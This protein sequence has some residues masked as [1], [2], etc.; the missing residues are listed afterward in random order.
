MESIKRESNAGAAL[1]VLSLIR[2]IEKAAILEKNRL[3]SIACFSW[4]LEWDT[5]KNLKS[6]VA[7]QTGNQTYMIK[8]VQMEIAAVNIW[9]RFFGF[10]SRSSSISAPPHFPLH[11]KQ[12]NMIP[13]SGIPKALMSETHVRSVKGRFSVIAYGRK[14]K[15]KIFLSTD[16]YHSFQISLTI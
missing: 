2:L 1:S 5:L 8:S 10:D 11:R 12:P 13:T 14:K 7:N 15:K 16:N 6:I 4:I 3:L 9:R